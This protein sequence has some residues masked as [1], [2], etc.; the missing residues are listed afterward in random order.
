[1]NVVVIQPNGSVSSASPAGKRWTLGELQA[2]VGGYIGHRN[3]PGHLVVLF[4]EEGEMRGLEINPS[5]SAV[6]GVAL[7]GVVVIA[8][9]SV[10]A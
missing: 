10:L 4:D 5:G 7:R 6:A 1:M 2:L 9:A 8:P 3:L